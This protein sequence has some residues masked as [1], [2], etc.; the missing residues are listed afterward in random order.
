MGAKQRAEA[1]KRREPTAEELDAH[2]AAL[3]K[4]PRSRVFEPMTQAEYTAELER[5]FGGQSPK[6][7]G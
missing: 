5:V 2:I 4:R 6:P 3:R 1:E 7:Q